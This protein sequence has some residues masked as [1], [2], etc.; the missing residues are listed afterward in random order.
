M[1]GIAGYI[2]KSTIDKKKIISCLGSMKNRG[3]DYQ[4]FTRLK[5]LLTLMYS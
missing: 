3:P 4:N 5:N 1:C 2:G